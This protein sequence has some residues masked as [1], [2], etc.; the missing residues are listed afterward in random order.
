MGFFNNMLPIYL[1]VDARLPLGEWVRAVKRE[2]LEAFANQDVPFERLAS[3]PEFA[4]YSQKAG[5]YQGLF[6]FQDAR[7]RQTDW[8]GLAHQRV[9]I[10]Q[11]GAT[12]DLGLWLVE[13]AAGLEGGINFNADLFKRETAQLIRKRF[14]ALL[15]DAAARPQ[16]TI[17]ELLEAPGEEQS[18][19]RAWHA[20]RRSEAA[21]E[22]S[23]AGRTANAKVGEKSLGETALAGIWSAL[24]GIDVAQIAPT[25]NFFDLGGSSLLAMQ[26]V[27]E[28][29][30]KLGAKVDPRRY[31]YESL[32]Q[33]AGAAAPITTATPGAPGA[34]A[35]E[36]GLA[37]IWAEL[38]GL[39]AAQIQP[40]DNFFDLGGSS[41]LA[42]RAVTE[43]E[44]KLGLRIDPRRYVFE[45]LRQ[46]AT[47]STT[48][49]A[50]TVK[51]AATQA[52]PSKSRLFGLFGRGK[53]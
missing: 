36:T 16:A 49:V 21:Q 41:L 52:P 19:W 50:E 13:G 44:Q 9:S 40:G 35:D 14:L 20:S 27:A 25:D 33:L 6:S 28:A 26:A 34:G 8:G 3:E 18:Q 1:K 23:S 43:G 11:G 15:R 29:E 46:L 22:A 4:G 5:L 24:L 7:E 51:P 10:M 2:L 39:D 32:R 12:E 45:S 53:S 48:A 17:G 47:T 37:R 42:M 38:L 31:V 30:R